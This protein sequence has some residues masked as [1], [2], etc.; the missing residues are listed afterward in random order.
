MASDTTRAPR[1]TC[2][3]PGCTEPAATS[4]G[5]G[6]PRSTAKAAATPAYRPG[7]NAAA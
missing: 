3:H 5:P 4:A 7:G 6:R 2:K 1:T